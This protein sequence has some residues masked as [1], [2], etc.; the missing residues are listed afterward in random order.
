MVK[1]EGNKANSQYE[2]LN[3]TTKLKR[4]QSQGSIYHCSLYKSKPLVR[5]VKYYHETETSLI[6]GKYLTM[7]SVKYFSKINDVSVSSQY[8]SDEVTR[9]YFILPMQQKVRPHRIVGF[10]TL[11]LIA[12]EWLPSRQYFQMSR[13]KAS[14]TLSMEPLRSPVKE[15]QNQ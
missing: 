8:L 5:V 7:I 11:S 4:H 9:T 13:I 10:D 12:L 14:T 1:T 2:L 3:T 6:S 15:K